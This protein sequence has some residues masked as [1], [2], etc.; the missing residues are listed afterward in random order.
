M[1]MNAGMTLGL[2]YMRTGLTKHITLPDETKTQILHKKPLSLSGRDTHT[3]RD[4]PWPIIIFV[5]P[6]IRYSV[7]D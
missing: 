1:T 5:F 7:I 3:T 2:L 4:E 6:D